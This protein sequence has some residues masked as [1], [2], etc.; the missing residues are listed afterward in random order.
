M[1]WQSR[2]LNTCL[3]DC[4]TYLFIRLKYKSAE[5]SSNGALVFSCFFLLGLFCTAR[6]Q[7]GNEREQQL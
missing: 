7:S 4:E 3:A 5:V 6:L 1:L 2:M